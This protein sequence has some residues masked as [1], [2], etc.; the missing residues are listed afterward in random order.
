MYILTSTYIPKSVY[1]VDHIFAKAYG[2]AYVYIMLTC[3][4]SSVKRRR[5]EM[6]DGSEDRAMLIGEGI[7]IL[8]RNSSLPLLYSTLHQEHD[9]EGVSHISS[10]S[11]PYACYSLQVKGGGYPVCSGRLSHDL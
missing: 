7:Y 2:G 5:W 6:G 8:Q 10:R 9:E 4:A 11:A 1:N 3:V